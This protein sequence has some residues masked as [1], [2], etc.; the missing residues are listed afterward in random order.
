MGRYSQ[1]DK[2]AG[3]LYSD[4]ERYDYSILS[5]DKYQIGFIYDVAKYLETLE[6][7]KA[8]SARKFVP[9]HALATD[10]IVPL[11]EYNIAKVHEIA[12]QILTL[13]AQPLC[14]EQIL[15]QLFTAYDLTMTYE[16]YVLVGSTV[17]SYLSWLKDSNR[18]E[19]YIDR[20]FLL[21][22]RK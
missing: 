13:C 20:N 11:A 19:N 4:R 5:L 21:W 12:E 1:I 15:Q 9:A 18:I 16:Q 10:N 7:V 6:H 17:R 2:S 22:E 8:M 14:F 3:D